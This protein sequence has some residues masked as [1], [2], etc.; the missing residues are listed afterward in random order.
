MKQ[1]HLKQTTGATATTVGYHVQLCMLASSGTESTA[2]QFIS[3]GR[4]PTAAAGQVVAALP[5][6]THGARITAAASG[7]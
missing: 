1:P 7:V 2:L 3:A 6:P 5:A 4:Q